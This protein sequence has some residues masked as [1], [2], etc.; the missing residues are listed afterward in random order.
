MLLSPIGCLLH[1]AVSPRSG[2][3]TSL[4]IHRN[5]NRELGKMRQQKSMFQMKEQDKTPEEELSK[6]EVI[7]PIKSSK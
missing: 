7:Y 2:N 3:V 6:V 1:K 4:P 5:K